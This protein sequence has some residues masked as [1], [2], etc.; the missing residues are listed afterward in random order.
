MTNQRKLIRH[1][2]LSNIYLRLVL[3]NINLKRTLD[4]VSH[5][6]ANFIDASLDSYHARIGL[7]SFHCLMVSNIRAICFRFFVLLALIAHLRWSSILL[8]L[9]AGH[10]KDWGHA[11]LHD[12]KI[13]PSQVSFVFA[14]KRMIRG[15]NLLFR[16]TCFVSVEPN[17]T[18]HSFR[19][20]IFD[21]LQILDLFY[22]QWFTKHVIFIPHSVK[23]CWHLDREEGEKI[24]LLKTCQ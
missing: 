14:V 18:T 10:I 7:L 12:M 13:L 20:T 24:G 22:S 16:R 6:E 9:V 15:A 3:F 1:L 4:H 17:S 8:N 23:S 11:L 19:T 21:R 5:L 2:W